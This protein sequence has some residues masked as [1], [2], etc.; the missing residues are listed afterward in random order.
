MKLAALVLA[1]G[2]A[3]RFG[4]NKLDAVI[5]GTRLIDR[6]LAAALAAPVSRVAL[7]CAPG[8]RVETRDPRLLRVDLVSRGLA[9]SLGAGI[10]ALGPGH[11]GAFVFLG[12]MPRVPHRLAGEL[13]AM[14]GE[15]YA[16]VPRHLDQPGHPVL[17]SAR[18][19]ADAARLS[20]DSGMGNL[21]RQRD[22]VVFRDDAGEGALFDIDTPQDLMSCRR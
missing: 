20:G 10:A 15:S 11:D 7:V 6:A 13:A 12:D 9:M 18:A 19:M 1:A 5:D 2:A 21:L 3:R 14:L 16:A 8:Q 17:L 22:D 4:G